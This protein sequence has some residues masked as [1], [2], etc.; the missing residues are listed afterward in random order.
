MGCFSGDG[1]SDDSGWSKTP[2]FSAFGRYIFGTFRD[3]A[4]NV[5]QYIVPHWLFSNPKIADLE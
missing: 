5:W 4:E 2:I 3:K 1:A